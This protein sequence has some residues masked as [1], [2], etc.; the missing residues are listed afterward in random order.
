MIVIQLALLV[1]VQEQ[2]D[3]VV[4]ETLA[5]PPL[6]VGEALVGDAVKEH[7]AAA[8]VIVTVCPAIVIVP[9]REVVAVLAATL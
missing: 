8:W 4:T 1:A 2:P 6:A 5:A 9:V 3:V 7:G